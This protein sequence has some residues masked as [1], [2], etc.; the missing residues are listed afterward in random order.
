MNNRLKLALFDLDGT[1]IDTEGQYSSF[2]EMIISRYRM[3]IPDLAFKVKGQTLVQIFA[4]YFPDSKVRRE[5]TAALDQWEMDMDYQFFPYALDFVRELK[6]NGVKCAIVTSS[7]MPKMNSA[8]KK[9]PLLNTLFDRIFTSEDFTASKPAPDCYLMGAETFGFDID[10]CVVFEDALNGLKAGKSSGI[11]TIGFTSTI[12]REQI[13]EY[14]DYAI[15]GY[16]EISFKKVEE[17]MSQK[18]GL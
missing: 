17:L 10:E 7:N 12:P 8:L 9:V 1:L 18:R 6:D 13:L 11:F 15:D 2:W 14:C 3:D 4:T 5:V 16:D